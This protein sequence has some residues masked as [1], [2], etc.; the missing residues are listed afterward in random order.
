MAHGFSCPAFDTC[1]WLILRAVD[2]W[3]VSAV[4]HIMAACTCKY[5]L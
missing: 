1:Y 2:Q 4:V 3:H 5:R